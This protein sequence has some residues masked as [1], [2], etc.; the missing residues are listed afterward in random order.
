MNENFKFS[1]IEYKRPDFEGVKSELSALTEKLKN[2]KSFAAAEEIYF[3]YQNVCVR[4]SD[5]SG[6][7]SPYRRHAGRVLR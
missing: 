5:A 3:E 4:V 1:R 6:N 7:D 2:A